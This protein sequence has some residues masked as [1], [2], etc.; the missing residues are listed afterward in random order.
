[1]QTFILCWLMCNHDQNVFVKF[2]SDPALD[3]LKSIVGLACAACRAD[4]HNVSVFF[5]ASG[6]RCWIPTS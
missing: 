6:V 3:R 5:A 4:G 2:V 1:M